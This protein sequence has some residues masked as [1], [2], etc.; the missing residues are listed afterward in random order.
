MNDSQ[1]YHII[2]PEQKFY[3][4]SGDQIDFDDLAFEVNIVDGHT[5]H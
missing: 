4:E 1:I 5:F 2:D 3:D